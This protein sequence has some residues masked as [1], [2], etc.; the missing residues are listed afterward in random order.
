MAFLAAATSLAQNP[1]AILNSIAPV[2]YFHGNVNGSSTVSAEF[3]LEAFRTDI[4][5]IGS[6][7]RVVRVLVIDSSTGCDLV[8]GELTSF[9]A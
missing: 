1:F 2:E 7:D 3:V 4:R 8:I 5:V 6:F 9:D